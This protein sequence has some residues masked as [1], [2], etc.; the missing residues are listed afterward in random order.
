MAERG[1]ARAPAAKDR[2]AAPMRRPASRNEGAR[3]RG[4]IRDGARRLQR[5]G[6]AG[7]DG[8]ITHGMPPGRMGT[9]DPPSHAPPV[10]AAAVSETHCTRR[11]ACSRV[12]SHGTRRGGN[13][14]RTAPAAPAAGLPAP[15]QSHHSSPAAPGGDRRWPPRGAPSASAIARARVQMRKQQGAPR[16]G[17]Q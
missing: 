10:G 9:H 6:R 8:N 13:P 3:V 11:A 14:R 4:R 1:A 17:G 5:C 15:A 16:A 7:G 2:G 12:R